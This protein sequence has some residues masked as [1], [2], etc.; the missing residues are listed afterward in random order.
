[1]DN[2]SVMLGGRESRIALFVL[3][4]RGSVYKACNEGVLSQVEYVNVRS[5]AG[6]LVKIS[7]ARYWTLSMFEFDKGHLEL[8][9]SMGGLRL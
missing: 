3:V 7:V 4:G 9:S 5:V 6:R 2:V 1:M 8:G